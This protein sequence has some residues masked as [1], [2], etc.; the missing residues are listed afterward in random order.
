MATG[1]GFCTVKVRF[2]VEAASEMSESDAFLN[3]SDGSRDWATFCSSEQPDKTA[4]QT[5]S[6]RFIAR[7]VTIRGG[8]TIEWC[9]TSARLMPRALSALLLVSCASMKPPNATEPPDA[10]IGRASCR[11]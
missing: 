1:F 5:T 4:A 3:D 6:K 9:A 11:E 7:S 8:D 2:T 10:Q